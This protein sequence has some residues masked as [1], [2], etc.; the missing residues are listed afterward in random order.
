MATGACSPKNMRD[1]MRKKL[2]FFTTRLFWPTDEGH[3]V[4]LHNYCRGLYDFYNYDI[5]L[6]SFLEPGQNPEDKAKWPK[7]IKR[8]DVAKPIGTMRKVCNATLMSVCST[9]R[10]SFQSAMYFSNENV[11]CFQALIDELK[12]DAIMIDMIRLSRYYDS[13]AEFDG[14]K[15]LFM[16]DALSKR[17][18][19]QMQTSNSKASITGRYESNL[20]DIVNRAVNSPALRNAVLKAE[21]KRLIKEE[22]LA[23]KKYDA[24]I[25]VNAIEAEE[26]NQ[27]S[28]RKNSFTVTMGADCDFF[29]AVID[30]QKVPNTLSYV[31][32]MAV[33]ANMDAV[34]MIMDKIMPLIPSKP[35]I[36]FIGNCPEELKNE[37]AGNAQC[38]FDG[39]VD[40]VRKYVKATEVVLSPIAYG[41]G[42]KTKVIEG[43]AMRMPVVTNYLGIDGLSVQVGRDLLMS[44]DYQEIA[45]MV[46]E[47]L[48]NTEKRAELGKNGYEYTMANHRW[49]DIYKVFGMAGL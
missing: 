3:K 40:D 36:H 37:Y 19:R 22:I 39:R 34:R 8:I 17:Y 44:N 15:V 41:T 1:K 12:P 33:A 2:L 35:I 23:A 49:E 6:Y 32:N 7:Y 24:V 38:V 31:G 30:V 5:Y 47:L 16:E 21:T 43:M 9:E 14:P 18:P 20:P 10:W 45:N 27:K 25:Y 46:E 11:K 13:I 28:G 42:V 4:L 29:G 26:M 48:H